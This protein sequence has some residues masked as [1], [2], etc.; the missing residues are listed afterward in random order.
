MSISY[1]QLK[2][3]IDEMDTSELEQTVVVSCD[4]SWHELNCVTTMTFFPEEAEDSSYKVGQII[5]EA[6]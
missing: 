5:L 2:E 6:L 4:G 1:K 3:F